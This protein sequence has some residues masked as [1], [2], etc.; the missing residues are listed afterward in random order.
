MV[1]FSILT[2]ALALA[3]PILAAWPEAPLRTSGRWI[4]DATNKNV[5]YA[6]VNWSG[7]GEV[8]LP[9][10]LQYQSIEFIV[11]K[12]KSIGLNSIRLTYAIQMIDEIYSNGGKD[13]TI[14]KAFNQGLG[15]TNGP[16]ILAK[17]LAKNPRFNAT[18]TRL[19]VFDAVAAECAKQQIYIHL[20]N[21][22][23]KAEW[24]CG[25]TDGNGWWGDTKFNTAN[26]VRGLGYMAEHGKSWTALT[27]I[28]LRNEPRD[29]KNNA[30]AQRTYNWRDWYGFVKQGAKSIH[31]NNPGLLIFFSGLSYDTYITPVVRGEALSPG[32]QKFNLADFPG[33]ADK[34]VLE[35]HNYQK[36]VGS[37]AT[38][39]N[40]LN[41]NGF[42]AHQTNKFPV[43]LTEFGFQMDT[44]TYK[45]VYATCL[46]SFLSQQKAGWFLWVLSGSY[47]IRSG[48]QDFEEGWGLLNHDWS[49]WRSK[50]YVNEQLVPM[51]R[52]TLS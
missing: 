9:D 27:S 37:C 21:H 12:I 10:G 16:K 26:W 35:I 18:T 11:S 39:S 1:K 33:Y 46:A 14:D 15:T 25:D 47:Y 48:T 4:L 13:I 6:G 22:V 3:T 28:S 2:R 29:P 45:K 5:T 31:D 17:F 51:I 19:Q 41:N 44:T 40:T 30:A 43:M 50:G 52:T 34:I 38:L 20:D 49:D 32:T 36:D 42:Q 8:M 24:C 23:S 7:H